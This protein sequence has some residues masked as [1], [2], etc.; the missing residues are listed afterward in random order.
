VLSVVIM[1]IAQKPMDGAFTQW[2][3]QF[4]WLTLAGIFSS[5]AVLLTAKWWEREPGETAEQI[6][7]RFILLAI[8]LL[9][10]AIAWGI[11][12]GLFL[13][14][15]F[16]RSALYNQSGEPGL[17]A[18]LMYFG[19]LFVLMRW[20]LQAD[21]L[22]SSRLALWPTALCAFWGL[23]LPFPQPWGVLLATAISV[24]VQVAAPWVTTSQRAR[25]KQQYRFQDARA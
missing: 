21:P 23:F 7:R 16:A 20:W 8:G 2:G 15:K 9:I 4:A 18:F 19:G 25:L 17:P 24:A 13:E 22:R 11:D 14:M 3:P 10:G 12:A 5:W 6:P 1:V